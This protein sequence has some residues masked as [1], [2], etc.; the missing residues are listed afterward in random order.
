MLRLL[1]LTAWALSRGRMRPKLARILAGRWV[2]VQC[3]RRPLSACFVHLWRWLENRHFG[4]RVTKG[5][6]EDLILSMCLIPLSIADMRLGVDGLVTASDASKKGGAFCYDITHFLG[7]KFTNQHHEDGHVTCHMSQ[8]VDI[9]NL[10]KKVG[11]H[12][13]Q[14]NPTT[15]DKQKLSSGTVFEL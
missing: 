11:L 6:A 7:I 2:R 4:G 5:V 10:I 13:T 3:F 1:H 14:T 8:P 12:H 15:K 9:E